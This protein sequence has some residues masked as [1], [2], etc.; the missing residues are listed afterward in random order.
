M[1]IVVP[2]G[3]SYEFYV[4]LMKVENNVYNIGRT[5]SEL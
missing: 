3:M 5:V 2:A 4:N 1:D